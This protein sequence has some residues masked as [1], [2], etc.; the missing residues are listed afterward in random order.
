M[1]IHI[2]KTKCGWVIN[3]DIDDQCYVVA[4]ADSEEV[5]S[6]VRELTDSSPAMSLTDGVKTYFDR[7]INTCS[8]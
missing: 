4:V 6:V 8:E 1:N 5:L 3:Y 7:L 2:R